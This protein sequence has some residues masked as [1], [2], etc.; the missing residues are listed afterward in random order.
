MQSFIIAAQ[1]RRLS[2]YGV[3]L[4][5]GVAQILVAIYLS[6]AA[7][8]HLPE[9]ELKVWFLMLA[10]MPFIGLF[11]LGANVV[12][13]HKIASAE[14]EP[15]AVG[16]IATNFLTTVLIVLLAGTALGL[17]G[18]WACSKLNILADDAVRLLAALMLASAVRVIANV[19]HGLL[20]AQGENVYDKS[21]RVVATITL[22][23]VAGVGLNSGMSLWAMPLAWCSGGLLSIGAAL[24]RQ[25]TRWHVRLRF[26]FIQPDA[27]KRL[28]KESL[29]YLVIALPGQLVFNAT[30]F[31][32]AARLPTAYTVAYGLTQQLLAGISLVVS[33]PITVA[34]PKL[35]ET[36]QRERTEAR[37]LLLTTLTNAGIISAA[38]LCLVAVSVESITFLWLGKQVSIEPAF[39][40]LYFVVMFVEWQQTAATTATMATGNFKFALVTVVSAGLVLATMPWFIS[41]IGFLGVPVALLV[42]QSLTCHPHNFWRAFQTYQIRFTDYLKRL[43]FPVVTAASIL[44]ASALANTFAFDQLAQFAIPAVIACMLCGTGIYRNTERSNKKRAE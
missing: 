36:Y 31:I 23:V 3:T 10:V 8:S 9:S 19:F 14:Y 15:E 22:A 41:K 40:T 2:T 11:E 27:V 38:C 29:R 39:M 13:P 26:R 42:A 7:F 28:L 17:A 43:V 16:N 25:H 33:L 35:A 4:V 30:P 37:D 6:R 5:S 21:L 12:L 44:G 24:Y 20:Y 32:I 34:T 1:F 18:L